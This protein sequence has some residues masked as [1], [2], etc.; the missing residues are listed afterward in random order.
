METMILILVGVAVVAG[1]AGLAAVIAVRL[2][3]GRPAASVAPVTPVLDPETL[4]R[5]MADEQR[6]LAVEER[7]AAIKVAVDHLMDHNRGALASERTLH[8]QELDAKKSLIDQQLG[9]MNGELGKI[10]ELVRSL[11]AER[12][13]KMG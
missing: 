11:E 2:S 8:G 9:A 1:I 4:A 6:R 3:G 10:S 12:A 13:A 5:R 7:D